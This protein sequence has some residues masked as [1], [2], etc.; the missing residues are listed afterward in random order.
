MPWA[1]GFWQNVIAAVE[2]SVE[3][4]MIMPDLIECWSRLACPIIGLRVPALPNDSQVYDAMRAAFPAFNAKRLSPGLLISSFPI[5]CFFNIRNRP[6]MKMV[7]GF[8]SDEDLH[9]YFCLHRG[10]GRAVSCPKV[11]LM[12]MT[13]VDEPNRVPHRRTQ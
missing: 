7:V 4:T 12:A 9:K 3:C 8:L 10:S 2:T 6:L 1:Y 13:N 11:E 5:T